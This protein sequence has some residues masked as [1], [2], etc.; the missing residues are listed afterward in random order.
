[1]TIAFEIVLPAWILLSQICA[2]GQDVD[3]DVSASQNVGEIVEQDVRVRDA[4]RNEQPGTQSLIV[5]EWLLTRDLS[6]AILPTIQ[7]VVRQH[8]DESRWTG[9]LDATLFAVATHPSTSDRQQV[10]EA[11][12]RHAH[13]IAVNEILLAKSL[14]DAFASHGLTDS[15]TL[16]RAVREAQLN[17]T[18]TGQ[19]ALLQSESQTVSK[20]AVAY[21]LADESA[22]LVH[23]QSPPQLNEVQASYRR[24]M[25]RDASE[26][27][28]RKNWQDALLLWHHLQ[29]RKLVSPELYLDAARCFHALMAD[30]DALTVLR[31]AFNVYKDE[32][33][34]GFF[35]SIGDL[36]I[37]LPDPASQTLA[38]EAFER[39]SALL[40]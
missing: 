3:A 13:A 21:V 31:E 15:T 28:R 12:L 9:T 40:H 36:A 33:N 39:A 18:I 16:R 32:I 26:L 35:E 34:A 7:S 38:R 22:L 5:T 17:F 23:L 4:K 11:Q 20:F 14:L 30:S 24:V 29:Q 6:P 10:R 19:G 25:H 2:W 37:E 8:P 27:M 1:M